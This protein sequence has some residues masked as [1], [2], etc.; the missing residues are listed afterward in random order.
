MRAKRVARVRKR[1]AANSVETPDA[2]SPG[3]LGK[4]IES[5]DEWI[6][7]Q[8]LVTPWGPGFHVGPPEEIQGATT[9]MSR[10]Q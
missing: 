8:A 2:S 1:H 4:G 6:T 10:D 7:L 3:E 5:E 9:P